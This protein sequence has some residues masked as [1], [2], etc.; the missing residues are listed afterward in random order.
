MIVTDIEISNCQ[1][2]PQTA[3]Q[4]ASVCLTLPNQVVTL[5][6]HLELPDE[7]DEDARSSAFAADAVRQLLRMP[8]FRSGRTELRFA[9]HLRAPAQLR[10]A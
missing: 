7:L 3:R 9:D 6:C 4:W 2:C 10:A 1:V 8:E 5:F